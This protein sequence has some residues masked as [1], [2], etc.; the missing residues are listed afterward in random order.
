MKTISANQI[1]ILKK[2]SLSILLNDQTRLITQ[3]LFFLGPKKEKKFLI[4]E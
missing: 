1:N 4:R 3:V 2:M